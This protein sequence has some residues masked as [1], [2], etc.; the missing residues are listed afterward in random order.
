MS[1]IS[2]TKVSYLPVLKWEVIFFFFF[3]VLFLADEIWMFSQACEQ[4]QLIQSFC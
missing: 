2:I 3:F 4:R 1:C